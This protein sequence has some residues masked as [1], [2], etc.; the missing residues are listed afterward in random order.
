MKTILKFLCV[1]VAVALCG[2]NAMYTGY[3]VKP[4]AAGLVEA[5]NKEQDLASV[6]IKAGTNGAILPADCFGVGLDDTAAKNCAAKR[7]QAVSTLIVLS[8]DMCYEHRRSMYG[9]EASW[10][11]AF[12]T[13]TN[14][15][16]GA[17]SVVH[18]ESLRPVLAAL[19]LLSSS[20]RSLIN[21]TVYKQMLVQ[22]VDAKIVEIRDTK[23]AHIHA[24]LSQPLDKYPVY[25]A[26]N[27]V[28]SLH[29][30]CS[31]VDGLEKALRE[32]TEGTTAQKISRLRMTLRTLEVNYATHT[33]KTSVP[34]RALADRIA[35]VTQA[36]ISE[37]TR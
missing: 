10:N 17:A 12:G 31:F 3:S 15:F 2:C 33:D 26:L 9:R 5:K 8:S 4:L 22:A 29:N 27:D 18:K 7:N 13:M 30:N 36:L 14:V 19:A 6:L 24:A 1:T 25:T 11:I 34:A 35:A 23:M 28:I 20:E 21:E 16:A 32:G 37:E